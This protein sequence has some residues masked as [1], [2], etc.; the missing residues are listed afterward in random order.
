MGNITVV[1]SYA[2][3]KSTGRASISL[4]VRELVVG[5]FSDCI[6]MLL[7]QCFRHSA[8]VSSPTLL[9]SRLPVAMAKLMVA[10]TISFAGVHFSKSPSLY[11][12]DQPPNK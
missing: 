4:L 7:A 9:S 6:I 10:V 1:D 8:P 2:S 5:H 11:L 12:P 3:A